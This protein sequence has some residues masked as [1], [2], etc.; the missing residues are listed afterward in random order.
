MTFQPDADGELPNNI[1]AQIAEKPKRQPGDS[2]RVARYERRVGWFIIAF[3]FLLNLWLLSELLKP[4]PP[5]M[6]DHLPVTSRATITPDPF[7]DT[8]PR[9]AAN[10]QPPD[11]FIVTSI[12]LPYHLDLPL[13]DPELV[14]LDLAGNARCRLTSDDSSD[15]NP[16][17]SPDGQSILYSRLTDGLVWLAK[18]PLPGTSTLTMPITGLGVDWSPD[19]QRLVVTGGQ[20]SDDFYII[21]PDGRGFRRLI[22]DI[23]GFTDIYSARWSP[24][25]SRIVFMAFRPANQTAYGGGLDLYVIDADGSNLRRLTYNLY[26]EWSPVWLANSK[27]AFISDRQRGKTGIFTLGVDTGAFEQLSSNSGTALTF[28]PEQNM[29]YYLDRGAIYRMNI[30]GTGIVQLTEPISAVSIDVWMPKPE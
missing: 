3:I 25:G 29:L 5:L 21:K 1:A 7:L 23:N 30:D 2:E 10:S 9:C 18:I 8:L 20:R 22:P 19:G 12:E 6:N 13:I 11:G 17:I 28:V 27:I 15:Y 14:R 16:A 26:L 24:D 4:V